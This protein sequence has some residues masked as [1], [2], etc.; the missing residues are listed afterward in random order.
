MRGT[1]YGW[2][3]CLLVS[4][5]TGRIS[6]L[7]PGATNVT[8][9]QPGAL[10][11]T[12][13]RLLNNV[14]YDN[15]VTALLRDTSGPA[16]TFP[17]PDP[18][19]G[20]SNNGAQTVTDLNASAYDGA[21]QTLAHAA[22]QNLSAL[23]PCSTS[24]GQ[25]A[26]CASQFISS[27]GPRAFRR[28][29]TTDDVAGLQ[30]V[31]DTARA[32]GGD[33]TA[34]IEMVLYA[35]LSS[36]SFLYVPELGMDGPSG[37]EVELGP[38]EKASALSYFL[39]GAPPDDTLMAAAANNGLETP[40]QLEAQSRRLLHD[41]RAHAQ[42]LRFFTEWFEI[43]PSTKDAT[44][45]PDYRTLSPSFLLE[46]PALIDDV[47]F[48]GDG[49]LQT[50]LEANYTFV[51]GALNT[52]YGLPGSLSGTGLTK[53]SLAG[54]SRIGVL[55]HGSWLSRHSDATM[56]SPI[57]RG[58]FVRRRLL[59]ESLPPPPPGLNVTPPQKSDVK[60][61]RQLFDAHISNPSCSGCH[62][63]IDPVGNGFEAFDGEGGYRTTENGQ[64]ID[65]SGELTQTLDA[66]GAFNGVPE[67]VRRLVQSVEV[68]EC[69][70]RMLFRFGSAQTSVSTEQELLYEAPIPLPD[71]YQEL[72]VMYVRSKLFWR[73]VV[74]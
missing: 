13:V 56:S 7:P 65:A 12:R 27:F 30:G 35:M 33:F 63:L 48:N 24:A 18:Q 16:R 19:S 74:P 11:S 61:T 32:H 25:E 68:R 20:F 70:A 10:L 22:V 9:G 39:L 45:Y 60:T 31:Y 26:S 38:Y 67:L 5:C 64:P 34:G 66:N 43:G 73:R 52:F 4:A 8:P 40:D 55:T 2:A 37:S 57:K 72:A 36:A 69:F 29:L 6:G 28:P 51:D 62:N 1:R 71:S 3:A 15:T 21:A 42:A 49:R 41:V 17:A 59:C 58:V 46:T 50:L 23:L 44:V 47:V 54:T 53:V 14:E